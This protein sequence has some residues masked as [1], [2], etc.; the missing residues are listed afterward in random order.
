MADPLILYSVNTW[1]SYVIGKRYYNDQHYIWCTPYFD[2]TATAA[3]DATTPP[4]STPFDILHGL[5]AEVHRGERH[6]TKI[7]ENKVGILRG[8]TYKRAAGIISDGEERD[9][10]AIVDQAETRDFRPLLY[11]IPYRTVGSTVKG[12]PITKRAHPLSVEYIIEA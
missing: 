8:A 4:T 7:A 1:L 10:A 5:D 3:V 9:I 2:T 6:S 12:V 11:V